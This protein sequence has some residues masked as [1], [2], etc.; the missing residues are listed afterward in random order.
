MFLRVLAVTII[1]LLSLSV[2]LL[3]LRLNSQMSV[4][5]RARDAQE[6]FLNALEVLAK[7]MEKERKFECWVQSHQGDFITLRC[8]DVPTKIY[9][10]F[11]LMRSSFTG[12]REGNNLIGIQVTCRFNYS[13]VRAEYLP[14]TCSIARKGSA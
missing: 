14:E 7:E 3:I 13:T 4:A 5:K 9:T 10:L 12:F 2:F 8:P 6:G 11:A 1:A